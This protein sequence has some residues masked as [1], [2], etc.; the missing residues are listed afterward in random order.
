MSD[1]LDP[2]VK[3]HTPALKAVVRLKREL[4]RPEALMKKL[5]AMVLGASLDSFRKQELGQFKWAV[6]YP[7]QSE[8]KLNIAGAVSDFAAGKSS[9]KAVRFVDKPALIDEGYRGGLVASMT[10]RPLDST[11]FEV[12]TN[13]PYAAKQF[14]G[15]PTEQPITQTV[16][17]GIRKFLYKKN[18]GYTKRGEPYASKL[19]PLLKKRRLRTI[20]GSRPFVGIFSELWQDI[21]KAIEEHYERFTGGGDPSRRLM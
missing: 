6:R 11:S 4:E 20:V 1:A 9:P 2:N 12:G 17:Q 21:L 16:K 15:G 5:G 19:E 7:N 13:K 8:P 14:Y 3:I 18:G 10:Y